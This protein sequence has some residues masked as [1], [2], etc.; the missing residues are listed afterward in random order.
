MPGLGFMALEA[1]D[2]PLQIGVAETQQLESLGIVTE[3]PNP[4]VNSTIVSDNAN[5]I[6]L[7]NGQEGLTASQIIGLPSIGVSQ[8]N[9]R[10][11]VVVF[12]RLVC[13]I[14]AD[15]DSEVGP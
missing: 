4:S 2:V 13:F 3:G 11:E 1:F 8:I 10:E 7:V 9:S 15:G 5:A 14:H 6:G 12:D